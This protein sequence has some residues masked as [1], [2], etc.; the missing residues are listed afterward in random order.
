M[1]KLVVAPLVTL[2]GVMEAPGG[3]PGHKHTGWAAP[4]IG[5][6]EFQLKIDEA[7]EASALLLGRVTYESFCGGFAQGTDPLSQR[8][9]AMPKHVFSR[10]L[11]SLEWN[12]S[13]VIAGDLVEEVTALKQGD[14]GPLLVPGSH[15]V[16]HQLFKHDLIDEVRMLVFPVAVGSGFRFFPDTQVKTDFKLAQQRLFASG[17]IM[18][19][20]RPVSRS[21]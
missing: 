3:E 14:G 12:N 20:W 17:A 9:N 19:I 5:D 6:D 16:V 11:K 7:R 21:K 10:T 13:K 15:S 2:D 1:R 4:F 8:L 18:Q